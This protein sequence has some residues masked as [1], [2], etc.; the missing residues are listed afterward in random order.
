MRNV[1]ISLDEEVARWV[2]VTAAEHD[3]S[4]SRYVGEV[5]KSRMLA[6]RTYEQAMASFLSRGGRVLKTSGGYPTRDEVHDRG[7][8]R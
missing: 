1:T 5:L 4:V 8:L 3:L 2:R 7:L 6:G